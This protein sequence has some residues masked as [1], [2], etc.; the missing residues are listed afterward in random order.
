MNRAIVLA[1]SVILALVVAAP[2]VLARSD[3]GTAPVDASGTIIVDPADPNPPLPGH[4]S[5]PIRLDLSGKGK[6]IT[7]PD[8]SAIL[9][10]PG[11]FVTVTNLDSPENQVTL[12]VT[13]TFHQT[14]AANG[15][16]T[17]RIT[18]RNL[19]F[20]PDAGV[21]LTIGNFSFVFDKN[22]NLIKSFEDT[23]GNGQVIDV[24]ELLS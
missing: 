18:G 1:L 2:T 8:G 4:C 23:D 19:P 20:D 13:G 5:F 3:N 22:G 16:V 7:Q 10:S 11:L 24:C 21:N 17:T 14:T 15:D 9:T 6:V 12:N